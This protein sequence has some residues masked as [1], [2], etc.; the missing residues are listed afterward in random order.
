[1]YNIR[2][3]EL[4]ILKGI[5]QKELSTA[6]DMCAE[7][8]QR[9]EKG[10]T[11]PNYKHLIALADYYEVSIDWITG[12]TDNPDLNKVDVSVDLSRKIKKSPKKPKILSNFEK[13]DEHYKSIIEYQINEFIK[14]QRRNKKGGIIKR[15]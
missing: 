13:L 11:K 2:L 14:I 12:R 10:N 7:N 4:R 6:I 1:M 8:Y 3:K 9:V 5:T 15:G